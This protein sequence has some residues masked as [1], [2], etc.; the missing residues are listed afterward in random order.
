MAR[1]S[2]S[3]SGSPSSAAAPSERAILTIVALSSMLV[4]LNSTM[5]AVALPELMGEFDVD[6]GA[7]GWLV[8]GYLIAMASV[9]PIAGSLGD[10][11]GRRRLVLWGLAGFGLA[12]LGA[13]FASS[14]LAVVTL[15]LAQALTGALVM[16][17]GIALVR[18]AIPTIRRGR[19]F[20]VVGVGLGVGAAA[21]PPLGGV[22]AGLAD[23]RGIFIVN[24]P[25]VAGLLVLGWWSLPRD[26]RVEGDVS[27][28]LAGSVL[29][30]TILTGIAW[31]LSQGV[32]ALA[33][34]VFGAA[35]AV[36]VALLLVFLRFELKRPFPVFDP[37]FF[38]QRA[39]SAASSAVGLSNLAMYCTL[40]AIPQIFSGRE[41]WN[42]AQ[43]G[44]LLAPLTVTMVL[45]GTPGG[46]L[47]DRF[48]RRWPVV[49]GLSLMTLGVAIVGVTAPGGELPWVAPGL[50][51]AGAGL[52]MSQ[53]GLQSAAVESVEPGRSGAAAGVYSTSRYVG[54][55]VGSSVLPILLG[56]LPGAAS[57]YQQAFLMVGGAALLS[58]LASLALRDWPDVMRGA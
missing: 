7:A 24:A 20:G 58:V 40:L 2:T 1:S 34:P 12:S 28:D 15:R 17:N 46:Q 4:P 11:Y 43:T 25:L 8:T 56:A 45:V 16:P 21:G 38:A 52:G 10:H 47:A 5:V 19:A 31:L 49:T 33:G 27:F 39:F 29:L 18:E 41:G 22:L 53:S 44:L 55:I 36:L 26:S 13:A 3:L 37:R 42:S 9:Q 57:G 51:L 32:H 14:F 6:L 23:W 30:F 35:A 50:G 48:G 54:S